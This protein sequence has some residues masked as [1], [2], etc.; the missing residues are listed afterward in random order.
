LVSALC[1]A[2]IRFS[3]VS[4]DEQFFKQAD[5]IA[6]WREKARGDF[7]IKNQK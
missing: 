5:I 6:D 7:Y 3:P 2:A 4:V 1:S